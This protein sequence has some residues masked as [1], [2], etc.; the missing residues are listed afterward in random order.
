VKNGGS[1]VKWL[2]GAVLLPIL[3]GIAYSFDG[4]INAN[5]AEIQDV[6]EE[7]QKSLKK[8]E[9]AQTIIKQDQ[10]WVKATLREIKDLIKNGQ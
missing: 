8:I 10:I 7:T 6:K 2:L 5:D 3:F 4:R 1:W 9:V